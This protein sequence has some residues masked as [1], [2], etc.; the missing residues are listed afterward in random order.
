MYVRMVFFK[1]KAGSSDEIRNLYLEEVIPSHK[2]RKGI[3]FVHLLENV[4]N[5]DEGISITAWDTKGDLDIYEKSGDYQKAI[6]K[7]KDYFEEEIKVKSFEVVAS[8]DPV[9]L[10]L[11]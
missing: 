10:R 4:D 8:S 3:R 6:D 7:F 11:F 2:T 9:I 5:N 1:A